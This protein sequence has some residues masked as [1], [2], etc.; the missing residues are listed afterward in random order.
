MDETTRVLRTCAFCPNTC[1]PHASP[2][3]SALPESSTPSALCLAA[4][5]LRQGRLAADDAT[6]ALLAD[7][8]LVRALQPHCQHGLDIGAQLDAVLGAAPGP[9]A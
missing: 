8:R 7:R 2:E 4:L 5:A 1:R 9:R 6:R 3:L